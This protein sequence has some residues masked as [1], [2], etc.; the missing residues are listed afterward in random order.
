MKWLITAGEY[1]VGLLIL[2]LTLLCI[3]VA[4]FVSVFEFPRYWR[5]THK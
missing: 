2:F 3:I 5:R 1:L 4:G